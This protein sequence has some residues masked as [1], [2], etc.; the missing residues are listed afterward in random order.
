MDIQMYLYIT[1]H[2]LSLSFF[3][4]LYHVSDMSDKRSSLTICLWRPSA[5]RPLRTHLGPGAGDER[6]R[7]AARAPAFP[8]RT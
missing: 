5:R 3:L 4:Y 1:C 7:P 6:S 2:Y 8:P